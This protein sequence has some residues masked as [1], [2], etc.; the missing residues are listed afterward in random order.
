MK[1][2]LFDLASLSDGD[3][4][5]GFRRAGRTA[6]HDENGVSLVLHCLYRGREAASRALIVAGHRC[7]VHE[8]AAL[9]DTKRIADLLDVAP[10]SI[11]LH[12]PDGWTALHLAAFFGRTEA[13]MLLVARGAD[14][15]LWSR[16]FER[17]LPIH[18]AAAGR[19]RDLAMIETLIAATPDVDAIQEE[20]YSALLIAA[21]DGKTEWIEALRKAGADPDRRTKEGK[22]IAELLPRR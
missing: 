21:S 22:G 20:G 3:L 19:S 13:A 14:A 18:A 5:A 16:S 9:G 2:D 17:N 1:Q 6:I 12:S 7:G 10:W 15:G 8:A 4:A 11:D